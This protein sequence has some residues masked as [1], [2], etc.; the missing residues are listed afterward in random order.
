[1]NNNNA[2]AEEEE[3][4]MQIIMQQH[5]QMMNFETCKYCKNKIT[6]EDEQSNKVHMI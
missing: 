3:K 2:A 1:M 6:T 5:E 4:Q